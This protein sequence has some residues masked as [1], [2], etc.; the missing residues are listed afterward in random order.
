MEVMRKVAP[1]LVLR[2]ALLVAVLACAVLVVE[3]QNA[4]DPAF[5]GAGSGCAAVRRSPYSHLVLNDWID[6]PLPVLGL[7]LH[8]GLLALAVVARDKSQTFFVAVGAAIG[9]CFAIALVALQAI[10]I[11][12]FCKWCLLVDGSAVVAA[13]AAAVVHLDAARSPGYE[14]FLY[15]LSQRRVQVIAWLGG[16]ALVGGLPFVWGEYPVVPPLPPAVAA[17]TVPGKATIVS[18]TDFECPFCRKLSPVL[19]EVQENWGDRVVLVRKMAPLSFH[20]GAMPAALAY[21]CT[22]PAQREEMAKHLYAAPAPV[23][24]RAGVQIVARDLGVDE[25]TFA[26]CMESAAARDEVAADKALLDTL[27]VHGLPYTYLGK[28]TVA[29]FNPDAVRKLG[30]QILDGDRPGLPIWAML[31]AAVV[32]AAGASLIMMKVLP[33]GNGRDGRD[34]APR[35]APST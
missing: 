19:H 6:V 13:G 28:R 22:P 12:A 10:K 25:A 32:V 15:A 11:G 17:L 34:D 20:P 7:C 35:L 4:G 8:A 24:T 26:H 33:R 3:Y 29:G 9:G 1:L 14:A 2:V 5:C 23:L 27:D 31:A 16:A 18:F 30:A 21:V